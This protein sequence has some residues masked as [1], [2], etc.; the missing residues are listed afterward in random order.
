MAAG[1]KYNK[2]LNYD[3]QNVKTPAIYDSNLDEWLMLSA[4]V[5]KTE[6]GV[7]IFQKGTDDGKA[8]VSAEL[9]GSKVAEGIA[10][11]VLNA[12]GTLLAS[13]ARTSTTTS[14]NMTNKN[15][16]GI[17]VSLNVTVASGTGGLQVV[18]RGHDPVTGTVYWLNAL[19]VAV[20]A[21]GINVYEVCPAVNT[22]ASGV[23]QR[24][25]GELPRTW[26]VSV[27]HG[28]SSSYTYSVGYSLGV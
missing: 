22:A 13:A 3:G 5:V 4:N 25:S 21:T 9:T 24:T 2:P 28:D 23:K 8:K 14:P 18:I 17:L 11:F 16:K 7:F 20:V 1:Q 12:E 6:G 15:A 26:S 19:P 27:I 10:D